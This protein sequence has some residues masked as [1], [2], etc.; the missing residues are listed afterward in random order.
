MDLIVSRDGQAH[1]G[2]AVYRCAIG[3][4]GIRSGKTEGDGTTP[5]GRYKLLQVLYR[6]D[7]LSA[8]DTTLSI[9]ALSN[10]DGWCD[11][12]DD[13]SYN[14]PVTL[15]YPASCERLYRDDALYDIVVVTSH[16]TDPVVPGA[17][18][19]IF[20]HVA[21]GPHYPPT[22]GCIAFVQTDLNEILA[23]WKPETDRLV[24]G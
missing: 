6:G 16:N 24:I 7:R 17:G 12:P 10:R 21:G 9:V 23:C 1:F 11:A 5:A 18:S 3:R 15:P 4:Q 14:L 22:D 8:P 20:L 13:P 2:A 19:A